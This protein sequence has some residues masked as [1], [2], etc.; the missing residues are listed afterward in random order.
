M[1]PSDIQPGT[2]L[3]LPASSWLGNL[4]V[5][6]TNLW[7]TGP[8]KRNFSHAGVVVNSRSDGSLVVV[9]STW[10]VVKQTPLM[11]WLI[12][13]GPSIY[14]V[15]LAWRNT[16]DKDTNAK[17]WAFLAPLMG[18][19]YNALSFPFLM[20]WEATGEVLP[21]PPQIE[22]EVCSVLATGAV[23]AGLGLSSPDPRGVMPNDVPDLPFMGPMVQVD[24]AAVKALKATAG[25][26]TL[27]VVR[28][29]TAPAESWT[30]MFRPLAVRI[31]T[32]A[33][34]WAA[35]TTAWA[36]AAGVFEA[37]GISTTQPTPDVAARWAAAIVGVILPIIAGIIT[38]WHQKTDLAEVPPQK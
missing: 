38:R 37:S 21:P 25:K 22:G 30:E 17:A 34:L 9:E 19:L 10:P 8:K 29:T 32:Y 16:W 18:Q 7:H 35:T 12:A 24:M 11:G 31:A 13:N 28:A 20:I 26:P 2:I 36:K 6:F 33:I 1:T 3:L 23:E 27:A 15:P 4:I 5:W 14:A